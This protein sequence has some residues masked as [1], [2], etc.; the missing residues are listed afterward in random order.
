MSDHI[1][2]VYGSYRSDRQGIRLAGY[3]VRALEGRG[4]TPEWRAL[5]PASQTISPG[6]QPPRVRSARVAPP[7]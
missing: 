7:Y 6:G 4:E 1:L 3:L 2:I 5:S